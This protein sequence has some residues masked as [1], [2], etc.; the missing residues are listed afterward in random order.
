MAANKVSVYILKRGSEVIVYPA[1]AVV[2]TGGAQPDDIEFVN[3][4]GDD[5]FLALPDGVVATTGKKYKAQFAPGA[6]NGHK[7]G[8]LAGAPPAVYQYQVFCTETGTMAKGNS[9][10]EI[11][12]VP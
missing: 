7:K 2:R 8:I 11:I 6:A 4:T 9:D 5:V 3:M 12:V 1:Q 10:P